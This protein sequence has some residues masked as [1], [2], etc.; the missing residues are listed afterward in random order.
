LPHRVA[1]HDLLVVADFTVLLGERATDRRPDAQQ[2]EE[3]GAAWATRTRVGVPL[4][5]TF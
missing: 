4:W 5:S 3:Q 2:A 1:E